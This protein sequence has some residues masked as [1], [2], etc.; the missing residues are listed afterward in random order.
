MRKILLLDIDLSLSTTALSV[1]EI[2]DR[3]VVNF[4]SG[5]EV[6]AKHVFN[7]TYSKINKLLSSQN[8]LKKRVK[9]ELAEIA[10][11]EPPDELAG[12]AVTVMDGPFFSTMPYPSTDLYS[13]SHVQY[14]P[15]YSFLD[16]NNSSHHRHNIDSGAFITKAP[17]MIADSRFV[18]CMGKAQWR[19]KI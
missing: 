8:N 3:V 1:H 9:H 14:T 11:I 17:H 19:V 5:S 16:S 2:K 6:K 15:H 12:L 4:S 7:V 13:L 18:P 10:L